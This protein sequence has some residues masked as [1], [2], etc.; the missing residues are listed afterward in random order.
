[1]NLD[2]RIEYPRDHRVV[3][4]LTR[5][6][7]WNVHV[8]G[9]SEHFILH[10]LR[11]CADFIPGLDFVAISDGHAVGNIVYSASHIIDELGVKHPVITFGPISVLPAMQNQGVGNALIRHSLKAAKAQGYKVVCIYGDP[12]YYSRFG[13]H[14][15][16]KYDIKTSAGQYAV[17]LLALELTDGAL[18]GISGRFVESAVFEV[19]QKAVEA[20]DKNFPVKKKLVTPSQ[21]R[22]R[23]IAGLRY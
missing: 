4:E 5:E 20:Y 18:Q 6:A 7:F 23:L 9:C 12:R 16:E 10:E 22:F 11:K 8:P 13:F 17:A 14:C 19:D 15:A 21:E 1:M 3:E 2:I